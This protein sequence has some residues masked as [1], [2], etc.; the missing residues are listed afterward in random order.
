MSST[1]AVTAR[2]SDHPDKAFDRSRV[3]NTA[4]S[5]RRM[6]AA[7]ERMIRGS[8]WWSTRVASDSSG[9]DHSEAERPVDGNVKSQSWRIPLRVAMTA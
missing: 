2:S 7:S 1:P 4:P 3:A 8:L 6:R 9:L 5:G